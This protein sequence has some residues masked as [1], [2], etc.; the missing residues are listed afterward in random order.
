MDFSGNSAEVQRRFKTLSGPTIC[1]PLGFHSLSSLLSPLFTPTI[2]RSHYNQI[3]QI[4]QRS[5]PWVDGWFFCFFFSCSP[6]FSPLSAP[7]SK[8]CGAGSPNEKHILGVRGCEVWLCFRLGTSLRTGGRMYDG[9][10]VTT[11]HVTDVGSCRTVWWTAA[12]IMFLPGVVR[13]GRVFRQIHVQ[14]FKKQN[15][16]CAAS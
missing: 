12:I 7:H 10:N 15:Q 4:N 5:P 14:T 1:L 3:L 6:S 8:S 11:A 2:H 13:L 9:L 16:T